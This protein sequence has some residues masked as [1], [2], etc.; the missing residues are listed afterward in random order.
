MGKKFSLTQ[1]TSWIV[2]LTALAF[3][4]SASL[5]PDLLKDVYAPVWGI[6]WTAVS[7]LN[8]L[9]GMEKKSILNASES[10]FGILCLGAPYVS[11]YLIPGVF[12]DHWVKIFGGVMPLGSLC[13][14]VV[15]V[16]QLGEIL[17]QLMNMGKKG[18]V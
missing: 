9:E 11:P 16:I 17:P 3:L 4:A 5:S 8:L 18:R 12:W 2:A 1:Q 13:V 10:I 7:L 6:F 14:L 15:F